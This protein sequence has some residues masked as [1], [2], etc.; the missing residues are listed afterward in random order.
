MILTALAA[1]MTMAANAQVFVVE[2]GNI[3]EVFQNDKT[4]KVKHDFSNAKLANLSDKKLTDDLFMEDLKT[5][6]PGFYNAWDSHEKE[7]TQFFVDRWTE[8]KDAL[9]MVTTDEPTDYT[10]LIKFDYIDMGNVGAALWSLSKKS[11]GIMMRGTIELTDA[12]GN[13]VCTVKVNDYRGMAVRGFDM[14]MPSFGRRLA[15]FHKS[16]AKEFLDFAKKQAK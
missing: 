14:K 12:S 10:L 2:S 8:Y 1:V 9:K 16:L 6:D 5:R 3:V 13:N 15:L 11:G 7:F 4:A